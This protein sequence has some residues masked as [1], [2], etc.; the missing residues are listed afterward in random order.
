MDLYEV[1]DFFN[2]VLEECSGLADTSVIL[3]LLKLPRDAKE[4]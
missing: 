3:V 4:F 2:F 1:I